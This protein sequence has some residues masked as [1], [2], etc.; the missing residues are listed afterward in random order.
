M[1][2]MEYEKGYVCKLMDEGGPAKI[3]RMQDPGEQTEV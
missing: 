1:R 3:I 2:D